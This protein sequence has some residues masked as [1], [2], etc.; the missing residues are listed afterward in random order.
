MDICASGHEA[1]C[2]SQDCNVTYWSVCF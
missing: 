1:T 2:I